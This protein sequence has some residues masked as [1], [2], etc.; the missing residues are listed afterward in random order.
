MKKALYYYLLV[1]C[2]YGH[3]PEAESVEWKQYYRI[4]IV[5]SNLFNSG[6]KSFGRLKRTTLKTFKDLRLYIHNY[7][8]ETEI[9]TRYKSSRRF[10]K[11]DDIYFFNTIV[12]E[13]NTIANGNLRYFYNQGIG[14]FILNKNN[15][16]LT[17]ELG[18]AFDN[19]DYLNS[20]IRT[21]F[22]KNSFSFDVFLRNIKGSLEVDH[23]NQI[24]EEINKESLSR[25]QMLGEFQLS[26][27]S[28]FNIIIAS[29]Q[30]YQNKKIIHNS[31][32]IAFSIA[33]PI[34][35]NL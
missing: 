25:L 18:P 15:Y 30:E 10:M 6:L 31:I 16:N 11:Y 28:L 35:W 26:I 21:S 29:F 14:Y 12:Y 2:A 8:K 34:N 24:S 20:Q 23:F 33:K 27:N 19:S 4:G 3:D 9:R 5:Q 17:Y 22:L 7:D 1:S 32:S 13:K